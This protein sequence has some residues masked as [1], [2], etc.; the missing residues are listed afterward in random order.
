MQTSAHTSGNSERAACKKQAATTALRLIL[1]ASR[2]LWPGGN[3]PSPAKR[4]RAAAAE[5]PPP[6]RECA[7]APAKVFC[8]QP[9]FDYNKK[10]AL[11]HTVPAGA[12][13]T[14]RRAF[15]PA[16]F[17]GCF[18]L[19]EWCS[20]CPPRQCQDPA[21]AEHPPR[22]RVVDSTRAM[23]EVC[24][25]CPATQHPAFGFPAAAV[26]CPPPAREG[27]PASAKVTF[28]Q[29]CS[30]YNTKIRIISH[31]PRGRGVGGRR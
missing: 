7:V 29:P 26:G 3:T 23:P 24:S 21:A 11:L 17:A 14:Q 6:A 15:S 28:R 13:K 1:P 27:W 5:Y 9:C 12:Q 20:P 25:P 10:S 4:V 31:R 2:F 16:S 19:P 18:F 22:A 8:L 30:D